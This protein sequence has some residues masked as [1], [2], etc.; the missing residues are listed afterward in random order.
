MREGRENERQY[1]EKKEFFFFTC[2]QIIE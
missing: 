1:A 2:H